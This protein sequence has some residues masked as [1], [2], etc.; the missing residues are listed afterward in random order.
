MRSIRLAATLGAAGFLVACSST[1]PAP[2]QSST[3]IAP[4]GHGALAHCLGEHGVPAAP[5]PAI[6]PPPGVDPGT[7]HQAMQACSSLTPGP[8][9]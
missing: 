1:T 5:G 7:W 6:A 9:N 4:T 3:S 2:Q 8:S